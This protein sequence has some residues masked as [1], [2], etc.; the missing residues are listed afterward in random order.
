MIHVGHWCGEIFDYLLEV[1]SGR[2]SRS[3]QLGYGKLVAA[4]PDL[5]LDELH[6]E[7]GNRGTRVGRSSVNRFLRAC[8]LTL[9]K[10]AP[11]R[12]T[13]AVGCCDGARELAA[14]QP[15]LDPDRLVFIDETWATTNMMRRYGRAPRGQRLVAAVPHGHW[16]T[17]TFVAGWRSTGL[18]APL[19]V[20]AP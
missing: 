11:C 9:K 10:V 15:H 7:L 13:T 16:K 5:T 19:V 1:A 6:G 4:R 2:K 8:G 17:S 14:G 20:D 12:R 18:T 3:E